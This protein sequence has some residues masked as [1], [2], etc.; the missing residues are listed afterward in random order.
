MSL[1]IYMCMY[2]AFY[3]IMGFFLFSFLKMFYSF[4]FREGERREKERKRRS[5][6]SRTP[7]TGYR[8]ATPD[9]ALAGN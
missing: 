9:C 8:P 6:A 3:F 1:N 5:V 7:P 4:I 2:M